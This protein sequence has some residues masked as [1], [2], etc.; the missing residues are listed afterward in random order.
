MLIHKDRCVARILAATMKKA[1]TAQQIC[2]R[3]SIPPVQCYRT[4]KTLKENGLM[5]VVRKVIPENTMDAP[6][7]L[8]R[9]Q[10]NQNY[11]H[12]ENGRFKVKFPAVFRLSNGQEIDLKTFFESYASAN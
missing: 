1:L 12:F 4:I 8:Y 2:E 11:V 9:A 3:C 6:V 10:L 5:E 7:F